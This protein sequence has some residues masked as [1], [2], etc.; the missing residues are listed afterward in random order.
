MAQYAA[1]IKYS[2]GSGNTMIT[3]GLTTQT[4]M[5][6]GRTESAVMAFLKERHK[7]IKD[8]NIIIEDI[9]WQN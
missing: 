2:Y 8:L 3:T 6:K 7:S 5:L 9:K 4:G 1:V